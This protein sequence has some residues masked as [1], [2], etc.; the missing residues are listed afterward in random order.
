MLAIT[1]PSHAIRPARLVAL[2][3]ERRERT[4]WIAPDAL[5]LVRLHV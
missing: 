4:P 1:S 5:R 3:A 2:H